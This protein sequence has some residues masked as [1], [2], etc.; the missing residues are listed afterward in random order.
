MKTIYSRFQNAAAGKFV[1]SQE[2][3]ESED[4]NEEEWTAIN[5]IE[6]ALRA[7]GVQVRDTVN[8]FRDVD[9]ILK[10]LAEKWDSLTS[11]QQSGV[12]TSVAGK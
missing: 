10:E 2:E 8:D 12:A 11:L 1:A 7:V 5:D 4:Y 3:I 9:D 6:K